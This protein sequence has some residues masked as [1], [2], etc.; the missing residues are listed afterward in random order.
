MG[1]EFGSIDVGKRGDL[2]LIDCSD[3]RMIANEFGGILVDEVF[4]D[5]KMVLRK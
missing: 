4:I 1:S 5:G 2:A 3:Y